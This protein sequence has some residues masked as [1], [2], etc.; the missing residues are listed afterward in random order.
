MIDLERQDFA[1]Q[2]APVE[3]AE[4]LWQTAVAALTVV[5]QAV[6]A[7][8]QG[9]TAAVEEAD[10]KHRRAELIVAYRRRRAWKK[11]DIP[12]LKTL[13]VS[14]VALRRM[15]RLEGR[16]RPVVSSHQPL[17]S[18][19]L[20]KV[21]ALQI[22]SDPGSSPEK[23]RSAVKLSHWWPHYVEAM[24]RG[25]HSLA[26]TN[27]E[28]ESSGHAERL[29]GKELGISASEVHRICGGIRRLRTEWDGAANFPAMTLIDYRDWMETGSHW[30]ELAEGRAA[31]RMAAPKPDRNSGLCR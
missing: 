11:S 29:V 20:T 27:R 26:K 12:R 17:G 4:R 2:A 25:E 8:Q 13:A 23:R 14:E 18:A 19:F 22:L 1:S 6:T 3:G 5:G 31:D 30:V 15:E 24:Y 16:G 28:R 10:R 21:R 7:F 9:L